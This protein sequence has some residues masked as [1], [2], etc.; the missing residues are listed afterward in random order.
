VID[1]A[2]GF[3]ESPFY[4]DGTMMCPDHSAIDHVGGGIAPC[5]LGQRLEHGIKHAGRDP[6]SIAPENAV[7]LAILV[8]QV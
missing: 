5:Q 1:Q 4:A 3:A 2:L 6:S 8:R 7:P